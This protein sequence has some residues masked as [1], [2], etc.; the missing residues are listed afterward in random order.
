MTYKRSQLCNVI[1]Q[2]S[3]AV[4]QTW[5]KD[6]LNSCEADCAGMVSA[7]PTGD[8]ITKGSLTVD[9]NL[10]VGITDTQ[11]K[12]SITVCPGDKCTADQENKSC[13]ESA[14]NKK[15][16][17]KNG[18]WESGACVRGGNLTTELLTVNNTGDGAF[19]SK[20]RITTSGLSV[21]EEISTK[22]LQILNKFWLYNYKHPYSPLTV[23][24][25]GE[26]PV[27]VIGNGDAANTLSILGNVD[28]SQKLSYKNS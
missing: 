17:C 9:G 27:M 3:D 5:T 11:T 14:N 6:D 16:C 8:I 20:G 10:T 22:D 19:L 1:C 2:L 13:F 18:K 26:N 28:I 4:N 24:Y 25:D 15:Y 7:S 12:D 21:E 23:Q